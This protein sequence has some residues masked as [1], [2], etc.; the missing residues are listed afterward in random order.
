MFTRSFLKAVKRKAL[1]RGVWYSALDSVDRGILFLTSQVVDEV[2]GIELGRM[3]VKML[4]K[5]KKASRSRFVRR[6]ESYGLERAGEIA[7]QATSFGYEEAKGW[8]YDF[9]FV[10]YV[11]LLVVNTPSG[12]G[13]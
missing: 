1:R 3:I 5:L 10:R 7:D 12:W 2:R 13:L 9:D 11:T 6:M 8:A 4:A